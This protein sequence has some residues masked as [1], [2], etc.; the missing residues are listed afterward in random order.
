MCNF[1]FPGT[2]CV[3]EAGRE[4]QQVLEL[5]MW[6]ITTWLFCCC[7]CF[8]FELHSNLLAS[9]SK[10]LGLQ[11]FLILHNS[12]VYRLQI[13][14]LR[15]PFKALFILNTGPTLETTN[16]LESISRLCWD[17]LV[18]PRPGPQRFLRARPPVR[19]SQNPVRQTPAAP[20]WRLPCIGS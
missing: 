4:S 11:D 18:W 5:K 6:A 20:R 12:T 14:R 10:I 9:A 16:Q 13:L 3:N 17:G 19:V 1:G 8:V 15:L 7:H 2:R